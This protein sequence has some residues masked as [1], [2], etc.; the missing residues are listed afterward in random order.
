MTKRDLYVAKMKRQLDEMNDRITTLS[1][2]AQDLKADARAAYELEIE[3]LRADS[4]AAVAK[5]EEV[6]AAGEDGWHKL[7]SEMEHLRAAFRH[8]FAYFKSQL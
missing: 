7:V 2:Q 8:S 1:T 3:K 6:K 4:R 5:L